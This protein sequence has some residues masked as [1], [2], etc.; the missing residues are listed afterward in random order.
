MPSAD[1]PGRWATLVPGRR[2][3]ALFLSVLVRAFLASNPAGQ[4]C[5]CSHYP[6][7]A[8]PAAPPVA[9]AH[10]TNFYLYGNE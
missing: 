9:A 10:H 7:F 3:Y 6:K 4:N 1:Q 5:I 2:T 8:H